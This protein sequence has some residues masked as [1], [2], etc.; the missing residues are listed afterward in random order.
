MSNNRK[1]Y[2]EEEHEVWR[3]RMSILALPDLLQ[4]LAVVQ[5]T[6]RALLC[7]PACFLRY[8]ANGLMGLYQEKEMHLQ[9]LIQESWNETYDFQDY[10]WDKEQAD[11][12]GS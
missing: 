9:R 7:F 4:N 2:P 11:V 1:E 5:E 8:A 3:Y 6:L 12:K 10:G